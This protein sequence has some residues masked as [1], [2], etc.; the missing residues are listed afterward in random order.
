MG[1]EKLAQIKTSLERFST[2]SKADDQLGFLQ[3]Q[4]M[5]A[6]IDKIRENSSNPEQIH[7]LSNYYDEYVASW[8]EHIRNC[9]QVIR[10]FSIMHSDKIES[11][12]RKFEESIKEF[13]EILHSADNLDDLD[14]LITTIFE[15]GKEFSKL[16]DG[17]HFH[18]KHIKKELKEILETL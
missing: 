3:N 6:H 12:L 4:K 5:S 18:I 11:D 17:C 16:V 10:N 9:S 1:Y 7:E 14:Q 8:T 13:K 15:H 2:L